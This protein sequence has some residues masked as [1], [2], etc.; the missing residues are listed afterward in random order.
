MGNDIITMAKH[1]IVNTKFWDDSYVARMSPNEKLV[2][3]YLLTNPLTTIAG[4]YE[5]STK[6]ASF[7]T[8]LSAREIGKVLERLEKDEKII[9]DGDWI[10]IVNF[11]RHQSLNPKVRRGIEIELEKAPE[12]LVER[13]NVDF[14]TLSEPMDRLSHSNPNLKF[15][16]NFNPNLNALSKERSSTDYPQDV[17]RMRKE[18]VR[19]MRFGS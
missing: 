8:G 2:F 13:L 9:R 17:E 19:K 1:R 5:L 12:S 4:V 7:D 11:I 18:L 16:S 14:D 15:N 10:G 6:R 3:L